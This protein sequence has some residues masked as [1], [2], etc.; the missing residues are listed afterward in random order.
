MP[1]RV[2]PKGSYVLALKRH[3]KNGE[4]ILGKLQSTGEIFAG[5]YLR[6]GDTIQVEIL[7]PARNGGAKTEKL[8]WDCRS[9]H[10]VL[11]WAYPLV[12]VSMSLLP[13]SSETDETKESEE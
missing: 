3:P 10:G 12:E 13:A 6:S 7:R 11:L 8:S 4:H 2:F 9:M 5:R 1:G